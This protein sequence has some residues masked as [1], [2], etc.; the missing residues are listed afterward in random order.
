MGKAVNQRCVILNEFRKII[1]LSSAEAFRLLPYRKRQKTRGGVEPS[2][3]RSL[4]RNLDGLI[5]ENI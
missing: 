1:E 4:N 2:V 3:N 5:F